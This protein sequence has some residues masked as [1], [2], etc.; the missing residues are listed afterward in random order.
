MNKPS[1]QE[2]RVKKVK[3]LNGGTLE[4]NWNYEVRTGEELHTI[5]DSIKSTI[6]PSE[7]LLQCLRDLKPHVVRILSKAP[8]ELVR[9]SKDLSKKQVDAFNT[10]ESVLDGIYQN[11]LN[12]ITI[13]GVAWSGSDDKTGVVI[14]FKEKAATGHY[15]GTATPRIVLSSSSLG[16]EEEIEN[17]VNK[18]R[19]E[20]YDYIYNGKQD[21][22][23]FGLGD[24]D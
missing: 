16:I 14:T 1:L 9:K 20:V 2:V 19:E 6:I 17:I 24:E 10:L 13:T 15:V 12:N 3:Y 22:L 5:D 23:E 21:Q 7:S 8:I 4:A 18:L 11:T